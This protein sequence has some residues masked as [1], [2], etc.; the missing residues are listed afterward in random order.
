MPFREEFPGW[1]VF[2]SLRKPERR[3]CRFHFLHAAWWNMVNRNEVE[4]RF[5]AGK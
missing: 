1:R 2:H 4:R 5:T 3:L